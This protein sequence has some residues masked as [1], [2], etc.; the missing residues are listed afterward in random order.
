MSSADAWFLFVCVATLATTL[1][2]LRHGER[3]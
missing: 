3:L 1:E 2:L